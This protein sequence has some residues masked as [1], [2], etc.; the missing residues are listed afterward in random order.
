MDP[1]AGLFA[2]TV[3]VFALTLGAL[4]FREGRGGPREVGRQRRSDT[5]D[6]L[7]KVNRLE[8]RSRHLVEDLF[9]GNAQSMFKGRGVEFE[10]VRPYQP[11]DEVR[12]IDWNV[13][14]RLGQPY[15]KRFVEERELTVMLVVDI[16]RSMLFGTRGKDKRELAAELCAVLGF[17][18]LRNND[19]VG[20]VLVG[21][22][23]ELFVPAARGRTHLLRMLRDVLGRD[24]EEGGTRLGDAARFVGRTLKRRSLVF[25]ISDF[26]DRLEERDWRVI[27]RRHELLALAL[28]DP[29]EESLPRVGWAMLEDLE[30]GERHL[31]DTSGIDGQKH[32]PA[33]T[34]ERRRAAQ[35]V[36][37]KARCP[38]LELSTDPQKPYLPVLMRYFDA[39]AK[40]RGTA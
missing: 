34:R 10:E 26:E 15:V 35:Q 20:L 32:Y 31:V 27:T 38:L 36:L 4:A 12:D 2:A 14:A 17:A 5:S 21:G 25:W 8:I 18:A 19:R 30:S 28:R 13:T 16:S 11:G 33:R 23:I 6:L 7:R 3:V 40:R 37:A 29:R 1:I 9:S 22:G 24:P 39:R